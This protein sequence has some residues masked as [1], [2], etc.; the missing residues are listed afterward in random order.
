MSSCEPTSPHETRE[1]HERNRKRVA[2]ACEGCRM[3]KSK[4]DGGKPCRKCKASNII[5]TTWKRQKSKDKVYPKGYVDV[6]ERRQ[7]QLVAGLQDT[8]HRLVAAHLWPG[9]ELPQASG[10]PLVHDI[11]AALHV[12]EVDDTD[13]DAEIHEE[14]EEHE[15]KI[16]RS[17][18]S[19]C[20]QLRIL[21]KSITP[22]TSTSSKVT[23]V[24]AP[25]PPAISTA[26]T[27]S[28]SES[29]LES[30]IA[31][32]RPNASLSSVSSS[33]T[34]P[35]PMER[36]KTG[37]AS[38][39]ETLIMPNT[40]NT[41]LQYDSPLHVLPRYFAD[42]TLSFDADLS[43]QSLQNTNNS[44]QFHNTDMPKQ[45]FQNTNL[46]KQDQNDMDSHWWLSEPAGDFS[47]PEG[48]Y[49]G[50]NTFSDPLYQD[51]CT[52]S[53]MMDLYQDTFGPQAAYQS[54]FPEV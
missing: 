51:M 42:P 44:H 11:L 2:R 15:L 26:T 47:M 16:K 10:Q 40:P 24:I 23:P 34:E 30:P 45:Q 25:T 36:P 1:P 3:R 28:V 37:E 9:E 50:V 29:N 19:P 53:N 22:P 39:G 6:L 32:R 49:V 41:G 17:S 7:A 35:A 54:L 46:Q 8:Y 12:L 52:D 48:G 5:C 4:C 27:S 38:F 31:F 20:S 14:G 43:K 13:S 33:N 18:H 21:P